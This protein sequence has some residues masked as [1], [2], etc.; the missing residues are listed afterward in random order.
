[1]ITITAQAN[2]LVVTILPGLSTQTF[3][4]VIAELKKHKF[5]YAEDTKMW[6]GSLLTADTLIS[7]LEEMA[8]VTVN[9]AA[10]EAAGADTGKELIINPERV[11]LNLS[12]LK[13][14]PIQGKAPY[15]DYQR[16]DILAGLQR[17]RYG[18]FLGMGTGKSYIAA[19]LIAHIYL[20]WKQARKIVVVTT[21]I[22]VRNLREEL[23]K[24][25]VGLD[26]QTIAIGDKDNRLP[27]TDNIDIVLMSYSGFRLVAEAYKKQAKITS[28][29]P[30]KP[31]IPFQAWIGKEQRGILMLDESHSTANP[32]SKQGHYIALHASSFYY[33]YLFT[34]TPAD[35]P[36]KLYN[37]FKILDPALVHH[38]NYTD[39]L[40]QYANIG[41][42]F[43]QFAIN[44]WRYD[45]LEQL[46]KRF[47]A[48]YG[49]YRNSTD[50]VELPEH[51]IKKIYIDMTPQHRAIY[52]EFVTTTLE[53][54]SFVS[55]DIVNKFPY[56][57]LSVENPFL[58]EKHLDILPPSL[59]KRI[60]SFKS[61][62]MEKIQVV[63]DILEE[64]T[65]DQGLLWIGH[66]KTATILAEEFA[67]Y[68]PLV[69]TGET[70][71]EE[72]EGIL[73]T[74]RSDKSHKILIANIHVLNTSVT[75]TNCTWQCYV[76]RVWGYAP[77]EQS[78]FRIYRIGQEK[79]VITYI[80]IYRRSLDVVLDKNL[81]GKGMLVKGLLAK[82]FLNQQ[83]WTNIFNMEEE[84]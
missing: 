39:W 23:L 73:N 80:P 50:V 37:Q 52:E 70:P 13:Y 27:F 68:K 32:K 75:L 62:H 36:E 34:G 69:I 74:F 61:H 79:S 33:R 22:G 31:F 12:L 71:K 66:P 51:Y 7:T 58:L 20:Q 57:L 2:K 3:S 67:Q 44:S 49:I 59:Q 28:A 16:R 30:R 45:K 43:S 76:E 84:F 56:M 25:I 77:V 5:R 64:H 10:I 19:A 53:Q 48:E 8:Q 15:E 55:R 72:R 65:Q 35:K 60:T 78:Q 9:T 81:E 54:G 46:N 11:S 42:R 83:D 6:L 63:K 1:M 40:A 47:T 29:T 38:L 21:N 41:N 4:Y 17:N 82:D 24:F 26:Q 14:P 18:Y